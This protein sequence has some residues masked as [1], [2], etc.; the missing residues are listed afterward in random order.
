MSATSIDHFSDTLC[1]WAYVAQIRVDELR[2]RFGDRIAVAYRFIDIFG[3]TELKIGQGWKDRGGFD[4]YADHVT[5]IAAGFPHVVVHPEVWRGCR[6]R[7]SGTSHLFLKAVQLVAPSVEEVARR[8]RTAFFRDA[9]DVGEVAILREI[10]S[11]LGLDTEAIDRMFASGAAMAALSED[12]KIGERFRVEGSPTYVL[13]EGRQKL[14]GNVGYKV[15]EANVLELIE[16]PEGRAS[17]C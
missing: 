16:A 8:V 9:R 17:W 12:A 4:G 3:S 5:E 6:P 7:S 15:I 14:Y 10:V 11:E 2:D 1:I 13:N